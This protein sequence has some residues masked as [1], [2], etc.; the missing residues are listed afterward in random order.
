MSNVIIPS[1]L[2]KK[3]LP[4]NKNN[5]ISILKEKYDWN[6]YGDITE[7]ELRRVYNQDFNI[8]WTVVKYLSF[9]GFK[10]SGKLF[11]YNFSSNNG[12]GYLLFFK[13]IQNNEVLDYEYKYAF[14]KIQL[15]PNG[16][17]EKYDLHLVP[18]DHVLN[19]HM[20][21]NNVTSF[22]AREGFAILKT[23][24]L[25]SQENYSVLFNNKEKEK[26][27]DKNLEFYVGNISYSVSIEDAKNSFTSE[28]IR[29]SNVLKTLIK[30]GY[31]KI[32]DLPKDLSFLLEVPYVGQRAVENFFKALKNTSME[33][34]DTKQKK[35]KQFYNTIIEKNGFLYLD[36]EI[37]L[38]EACMQIPLLED[39][40]NQNVF[41]LF[42]E[43]GFKVIGDL[44]YE[45]E[46]FLRS[47]GYKK[48]ESCE[49]SA[50][51]YEHL[52][53]QVLQDLLFF[54]LNQFIINQK[55]PFID[56]R[57][58]EIMLL[59]L[60]GKTLEEIGEK[61]NITRERIRQIIKKNLDKMFNRYLKYFDYLEQE[62]KKY[63]FINIYDFF[64]DKDSNCINLMRSLVN[65]YSLPFNIYE[66]NLSVESRDEFFTRLKGFKT[67]IANSHKE[68]HVYTREEIEKY[69]VK[70]FTTNNSIENKDSDPKKYEFITNQLINE[71]FEPTSQVNYYIYKKKISK[72]RMCQIVFEEEFAEGLEIYKNKH[73]FIE[74]LLE[75][76]PE[77]FKNDSSRSI[78]A[79]LTRD[80]NVIV[81][82]KLGFF[83]HISAVKP[84]VSVHTLAPIKEWLQSQLT[85]K[86]RQINTNIAFNKFVDQLKLLEIDNE[87]AL[88]SLL[89]IHFP[90]AF[91][92][93]RSPTLVKVGQKR[94]KKKK[95]LESH[96]KKYNGYVSN[97]VLTTHFIN[98]LGWTKTMVEQNISASEQL[99]KTAD[100]LVHV[101]CLNIEKEELEDIFLY[102]KKKITKLQNS[103]SI[104][105]IFE[106]RKST[107]L[108]LNIK[109]S[110]V[111]Y[112]LLEKYYP[113]EFDYYRYPHIHPVGKYKTEQ[114]S[115]VGQFETFFLENQDYFPR[116][117]IY[118]EFV[119]E[120]GWAMSTYY[121]AYSK[122]KE[123]ILEVFPEEFAHIELIKWNKEKEAKLIEV[124]KNFLLNKME[125]PFIHIERDII[126]NDNLIDQF[127]SIN[128]LFEW[129]HTLLISI[130][131]SIDH[132]ILLGTKRVVI[133]PINNSLGIQN[134]Q[135]YISYLLKNKFD[136]YVKISELQKYLYSIDICGASIPQY[137]LI[138]EDRELDY[139]LTNDEVILKELMV[140]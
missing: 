98:T 127:P 102:I 22:F 6:T 97:E 10:F 81:L 7:N 116:D 87:H 137:Y 75:Y 110:R 25:N 99:L 90:N 86:I 1:Y 84:D 34:S 117:E 96:V 104:E 89:K 59:R 120:R 129:N 132:F 58:W 79:N 5:V 17:N 42:Q 43:C 68:T 39:Y 128:P 2:V 35:K 32:D 26:S 136:G 131:K 31:S 24:F 28:K 70:F 94:L 53:I 38:N 45:T 83:K 4:D 130:L 64:K 78:I 56:Q 126:A 103:F 33:K 16:I 46:A 8:F 54:S 11:R 40:F 66:D 13:E 92:Y 80:E 134:E 30:L 77:E 23:D 118:E 60:N 20:N 95:I 125:K 15:V 3:L 21:L 63:L 88:F 121:M 135:D 69:V 74:K 105:T 138:S 62:I 93:S 111:L 44:P 71:S 65:V 133:F 101:D 36:E 114:F 67:S 100:G 51:I 91:N 82:W 12:S 73:I 76:F 9:Q 48:R 115:I 52:P 61:Y 106:E 19:V 109:D 123:I 140:R 113:E 85:D 27:I 122:N 47:N 139:V 55:P 107:L 41:Q 72:A 14:L 119:Q 18:L 37:Q 57:D 29:A 112:H 124:L 49:Q 108:Q 50:K